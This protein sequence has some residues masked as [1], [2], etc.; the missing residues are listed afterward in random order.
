VAEL[1]DA[2]D[3]KSSDRKIVWVRA[4]PPA[5]SDRTKNLADKPFWA[6]SFAMFTPVRS[7][8]VGVFALALSAVTA[9]ATVLAL[10][11]TVIDAK[12]QPVSGAQISI[13]GIEGSAGAKVVRT[14]G[15]GH[16][17][18]SGLGE[19]TFKVTLSVNGTVKASIANVKINE[20]NPTEHLDFAIRPGK[21][22]PQAQ[23]K[24][25]VWVPASTGSNLGS[26]MEV[27][28]R[29]QPKVSKAATDRMERSGGRVVQQLQDNASHARSQ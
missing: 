2:L 4:P 9:S 21:A 24:H 16:Y 28:D 13:E 18:Y 11:G 17:S 12:G 7:I 6:H 10:A 20:S 27:D 19:G 22:L 5:H 23:G 1:A 29:R 26:W 25:Y 8:A 3:S 15:K 14:D